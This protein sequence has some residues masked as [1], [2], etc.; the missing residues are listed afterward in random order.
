MYKINKPVFSSVEFE[1]KIMT[2]LRQ[3]SGLQQ[4]RQY[5]GMSQIGKCPR[6]LYEQWFAGADG[7]DFSHRMAYTGYLHEWDVLNRL[8]EMGLA[9]LDR[10]EV[11]ADFDDRL[12]GHTDGLTEWGD[13]LEIKSVSS[14]K[15]ELVTYHARALH[16]H[17]G[18][19]Q[20]YMLYGGWRFTWFVYVNRE[21]FEHKVIRVPFSRTIADQQVEKAR[22][23]LAKIDE[24]TNPPECVCGRCE[25]KFAVE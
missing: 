25:Y 22:F 7:S 9:K 16:E 23:V 1:R 6:L 24:H 13:L 8:R 17:I 20:L 5:L 18:Q 19:V 15:F 11:V 4:N 21:T 2:H 14:H 12:R 10:R 3:R